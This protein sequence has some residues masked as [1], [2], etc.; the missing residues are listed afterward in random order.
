MLGKRG[1]SEPTVGERLRMARVARGLSQRA[2]AETC[3]VTRSAVSQWET[4]GT[5][6][7]DAHIHAAAQ[8]LRVS[9]LWLTRGEGEPPDLI[10]EPPARRQLVTLAGA[11]DMIAVHDGE[12]MPASGFVELAA[13]IGV[14]PPT[15]KTKGWWRFEPGFLDGM[16]GS[17]PKDLMA[18]RVDISRINSIKKGD[19]VVVDVTQN[20]PIDREVFVIDTNLS[21]A[22]MRLAVENDPDGTAKVLLYFDESPDQRYELKDQRIIGRAVAHVRAGPL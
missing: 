1:A 20:Q 13:W 10:P 12:I 2:I 7:D 3:H 21:Y 8:R 4:N 9:P 16:I 17:N 19:C 18:F 5:A 11:R 6:P 22:L 15:Q 14:S